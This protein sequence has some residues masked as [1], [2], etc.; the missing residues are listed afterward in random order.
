MGEMGG[1]DGVQKIG[2]A[3]VTATHPPTLRMDHLLVESAVAGL[4]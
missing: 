3:E 4:W 2:W 1:T